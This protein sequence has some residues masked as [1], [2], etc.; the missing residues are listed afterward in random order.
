MPLPDTI[1]TQSHLRAPKGIVHG[2]PGSGKTTFVAS[3]DR[4]R[5]ASRSRLSLSLRLF[6]VALRYRSDHQ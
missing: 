1:L 6:R 2:P 5:C 4:P 3:I